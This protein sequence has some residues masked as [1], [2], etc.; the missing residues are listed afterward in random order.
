MG[1]NDEETAE[2]DSPVTIAALDEALTALGHRLDRVGN[3][4][5]LVVRLAAGD[6]W[7]MVFN[8]AEGRRGYGREAQVPAL[9]D[10]YAIPYTFCDPLLATVSLHKGYAKVYETNPASRRVLEKAGFTRIVDIPEGMLGSS[11]GPG[12]L[13]RDLPV[14]TR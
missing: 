12:W 6:R 3:L 1:L 9:L 11:A 4:Q 5:A 14:V 2:F 8:I 7:D 13:A 10:A